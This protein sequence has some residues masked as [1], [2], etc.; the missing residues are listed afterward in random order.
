MKKA[1]LDE[2]IADLG[3][4]LMFLKQARAETKG[5]D[6]QLNRTRELVSKVGDAL[7]KEKN[8]LY[9]ANPRY[10]KMPEAR[11][12]VDTRRVDCVN[13]FSATDLCRDAGLPQDKVNDLYAIVVSDNENWDG[14]EVDHDQ[15]VK[16]MVKHY[17]R[18]GV[19]SSIP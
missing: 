3:Y 2:L 14:E 1:Q 5:A 10:K 11:A 15:I 16:L 6:F 18:F 7:I 4:A 12:W 13:K 17:T 9:P 8:N 19:R